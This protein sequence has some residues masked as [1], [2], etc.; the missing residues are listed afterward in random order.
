M[1]GTSKCLSF[2]QVEEPQV[3]V[4]MR[5]GLRLHTPVLLPCLPW[6]HHFRRV[7]KWGGGGQ[8]CCTWL[9]RPLH[10][11][12]SNACSVLLGKATGHPHTP[13]PC[14]GPHTRGTRAPNLPG[15]G[16]PTQRC[17]H[18]APNSVRSTIEKNAIF[19]PN[20]DSFQ[21]PYLGATWE[22]GPE[23]FSATLEAG[24][25][26]SVPQKPGNE[27]RKIPRGN[28]KP[29]RP[30]PPIVRQATTRCNTHAASRLALRPQMACGV[31]HAAA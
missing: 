22:F 14:T 6:P 21:Q 28:A 25:T 8:I 12:W 9:S 24:R 31:A 2:A 5:S 10:L 15:M 11:A 20:S 27:P 3:L 13:I 26:S 19:P 16:R 7:T 23:F 4:Q 30:P 18:S 17:I 1:D 29:P